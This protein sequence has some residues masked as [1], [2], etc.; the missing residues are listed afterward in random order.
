[1][2]VA[3]SIERAATIADLPDVLEFVRDACAR[4]EASEEASYA[5]E[6]AVEEVCM[7]LI[8]HGYAGV[9]PGPIT[10]EFAVDPDA[11]TLTVRDRAR[12]FD[13][14]DA[15]EPDL[16]SDWRSRPV[17]GLGWHLVRRFVDEI[18]YCSDPQKGNTLTLVK[19]SAIRREDG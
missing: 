5:I 10:I 14:K 17:G 6:L 19:R 16:I 1:M 18:S 12:A 3:R 4:A 9:E 2:R 8:Q 7:N 13:P 11:V 15:P